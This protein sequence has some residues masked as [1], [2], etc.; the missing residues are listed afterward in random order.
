MP[1]VITAYQECIA[2]VAS[3]GL[4]P[5]LEKSLRLMQS[6]DMSVEQVW[7]QTN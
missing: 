7:K 4:T 2:G 3:I 6:L 5:E 1:A